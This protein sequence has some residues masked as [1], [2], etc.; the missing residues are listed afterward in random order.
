M[1][2][3]APV[4]Y[5]KHI[6]VGM[7]YMQ[8][9][10]LTRNRSHGAHSKHQCNVLLRSRKTPGVKK[11]SPLLVTASTQDKL[12]RKRTGVRYATDGVERD[13]IDWKE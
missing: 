7:N 2:T 8:T 3:D 12:A 1:L 9:Q 5:S 13:V 10:R 11:E 4:H 6:Y